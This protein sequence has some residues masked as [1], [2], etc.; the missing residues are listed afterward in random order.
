MDLGDFYHT[1]SLTHTTHDI[2]P[3]DSL[4]YLGE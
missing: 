1:N 2:S 3:L 4:N